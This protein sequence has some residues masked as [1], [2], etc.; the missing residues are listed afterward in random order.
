MTTRTPNRTRKKNRV[1]VLPILSAALICA[2]AAILVLELVRFSQLEDRVAADVT[3]AGVRVGGLSQL[4]AVARWEAVYT[5]PVTLY[6]GENPILLEPNSLDFRVNSETMLASAL[7]AS[8]EADFWARFINHLTGTEVQRGGASIPLLADYQPALLR[9][10]LED[11]ARRY[12]RNPG[13]PG[14]DVPTLTVYSGNRG[15][16]LDIDLAVQLVD[17]AL[18]SPD[19][20]VVNLPIGDSSASDPNILTL[21]QMIID[22]LDTQG[23]IYDGETTVASVYIMDLQTGDEINLLGDVAF[24]GASTTKVSI[25]IDFYRSLNRPPNQDEAFLL[26]N[27]MLCSRNS[28]SNLLMG[29]IGGGNNVLAGAASVTNTMQMLGARNTYIA[30]RFVEGV[31][32]EQFGAIAAPRTTPNL[33]FNTDPDPFNQTTA[34]DMGTLFTMIYDCATQG[35]GLMVAYPSGEFSQNDCRQM[36]E[37]MSANDLLRLLQGGIPPGARI[38]HKNGWL[39]SMVGDAGI[40]FS[41]SGRDYVISVFLWEEA[42]FQNYERL[43]PLLEGISRAAWNYFNPDEPLLTPRTDLPVTAQ[44]CEGNYLPPS[45]ELTNLD[46]INAWREGR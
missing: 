3:V 23:F 37:L 33:N 32:N 12:D 26:A 38:A 4:E 2:A 41:P 39:T 18:R 46:D 16:R 8:G 20:R 25:M 35:S 24:S 9:Q 29:L 44:D 15:S 6:Y 34:E 40:V 42:E 14:Y 7:A 43:W 45:P 11:I 5:Q 17:A 1:P 10:F 30:A 36:L 21:R 28:S 31:P 13:T 19:N 22:Y 27:S